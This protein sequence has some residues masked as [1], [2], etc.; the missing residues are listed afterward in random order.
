MK[1]G[2]NLISRGFV[3]Q[4]YLSDRYGSVAA[5]YFQFLSVCFLNNGYS[6]LQIQGPRMTQLKPPATVVLSDKS[7]EWWHLVQL[8]AVVPF[9]FAVI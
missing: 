5:T 4:G 8:H 1:A 6:N 2:L 3:K 9:C 7:G